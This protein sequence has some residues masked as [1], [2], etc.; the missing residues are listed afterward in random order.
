MAKT[1]ERSLGF[2]S[3][4]S[5]SVGAMIGSGIFVLPGLAA[6]KAGPIVVLAYFLAGVIV[7]PAALSKA[8]LATAIPA[9]GG[10][11]VYLDRSMGPF[12][13]TIGGLGTWFALFFKSAFA[14]VGLGAY[15]TI[16]LAWP[17]K[18]VA[19]ALCVGL[20]GINIAGVKK[21]AKLQMGILVCV[22]TALS[23]FI[24]RGFGGL[25][26]EHFSPFITHG[27]VGLLKATGF[28]FIS[29]A[30][31][32]KIASIV[33]EV[34]RPERNVP[35]GILASLFVMMLVY[36]LIVYVLVGTMTVDELKYELTPIASAAGVMF[37][38]AGRYIWA[39]VAVLALTSMANAGIL[40]SSRY[41]FAM[42]RDNL[43]PAF[44]QNVH[45][46]FRTPVTAI[47]LTG[48]LMLLLIGFVN[49]DKL[50]K[51]AS[52]FQMLVFSLVNLS[53]IIFRESNA[54]WYKPRFHSPAYPWVQLVGIVVPIV[55][56]PNMGWLPLIGVVGI[57][58]GGGLWY[59]LYARQR[60][61][62]VGS[63]AQTREQAR[64]MRTAG[65]NG[66]S[67]EGG[68]A[69][70]VPFFGEENEA[71]IEARIRIAMIF[72]LPDG[73]VHPVFFDEVPDETLM[74]AIRGANQ[75]AETF[76]SRFENATRQWPQDCEL[77]TVMTHDSKL[78]SF[79]H[80]SDIDA[81]WILMGRQQRSAWNFL[82][83]AH[84]HWW[85]HHSPS[86]V[87]QFLY[88]DMREIQRIAV[89]TEPGPYDALLVHVADRLATVFDAETVLFHVARECDSDDE[90][91]RVRRYHD[92]LR[93]LFRHEVE[94]Q[95]VRGGNRL[96]KAISETRDFDL[97]I[98]GAPAEDTLI[99]AF[100]RSFEARLAEKADCS[101]FVVQSPRAYSHEAASSIPQRIQAEGFRLFP[102][103]HQGVVDAKISLRSK[104]E[105]F[106]H[107]S[108]RFAEEAEAGSAQA[109][110]QAFWRREG[111]QNTAMGLGVG[112]PH[113][114]MP[115]MEHTLLGI[116]T[117]AQPI[118]F[119][120][121]DES[122][123]D[124]CFVTVGPSDQRSIHLKILGRVAY[125]IRQTDLIEQIR[126][127]GEG[128]ELASILVALDSRDI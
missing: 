22:F 3:V 41:P 36:T 111:V 40:S 127:T 103:L 33:E 13:G 84:K 31:V 34:K 105:L 123:I 7:L 23:V 113:A 43:M 32:T 97:L 12:I 30:G 52:A 62:R 70:L 92:E 10:T 44:L 128:S 65:T 19:L 67:R 45:S 58:G 91:E 124:V 60:V 101:V 66:A 49:V 35:M 18:Y 90:M 87:T 98:V 88:R 99:R 96:Q 57:L 46:R 24:I 38:Q 104:R 8:E 14:L 95:I 6:G 102:F 82:I 26:T 73:I 89:M 50:A 5:I 77:E 47:I 64:Q 1:L 37:G 115:N 21:T 71:E 79:R 61:D 118:D 126:G 68:K 11:Y 48:S 51:L 121:P 76:E 69:I 72:S 42:S 39:V 80:A 116:F 78:A 125:L 94:S 107:I 27:W 74:E 28:V 108:R 25:Q 54:E 81:R 119:E 56:I 114:V 17:T 110:E 117:L 122:E 9:T 100:V 4:F 20:V 53:V 120:S 55:L 75:E 85:L 16:F 93:T 106:T 29:Y 112:M 86:S 59:L 83:R 15:L 2:W 63:L 109:L